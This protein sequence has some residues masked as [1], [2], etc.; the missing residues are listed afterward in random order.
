MKCLIIDDEPKGRNLLKRLIEEYCPAIN[1]I[2][3]AES[4]AVGI[5]KVEQFKPNIIFL[6]IHMPVQNGFSLLE[7]YKNNADFSVIITTAYDEYALE[8]FKYLVIDFLQKPI[9]IDELQD[10][11]VKATKEQEKRLAQIPNLSIDFLAKKIQ[12]IALTT[13]DG[14]TFVKYEH[15]VRCE[16]QGNYTYIY[17]K[18]GDSVLITKTLKYF[19]DLLQHKGFLRVHKSHL[20]NLRLVQKFL[21]GKQPL[22]EMMDGQQVEVSGRRRDILLEQLEYLTKS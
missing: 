18:E 4:V 8:A 2:A 9:D 6:D 19:D 16:A 22:V 13:I 1:A 12:K 3:L 5:Q 10:A 15:I 14:F 21:K 11:V 7:H 20:I 17:L